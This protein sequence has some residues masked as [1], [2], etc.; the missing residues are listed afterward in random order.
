MEQEYECLRLYGTLLYNREE[1]E[2][3][4]REKEKL[5][6]KRKEGQIPEPETILGA[7][8][9]IIS[10]VLHKKTCRGRYYYL[11]LLKKFWPR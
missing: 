9:H 6:E 1:E 5:E 7:F 4:R 2:W 3:G 8:T 10:F 11:I